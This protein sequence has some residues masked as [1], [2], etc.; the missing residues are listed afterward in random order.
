MDPPAD[1]AGTRSD[2]RSDVVPAVDP[3]AVSNALDAAFLPA[4]VAAECRFSD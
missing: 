2:D 4:E 3:G 1:E